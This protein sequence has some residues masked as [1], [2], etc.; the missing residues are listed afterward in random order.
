MSTENVTNEQVEDTPAGES[1][2]ATSNREAAKYR[3]RLRESEAALAASVDRLTMFQ[4]RDVERVAGQSL[5][6]ADDV[7]L[8]GVETHDLLED[9]DTG[10]VSEAKVKAA[11]DQVLEGRPQLARRF[12]DLGGGQ[13]GSAPETA[14]SWSEVLR[15]R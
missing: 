1:V 7:W 8:S 9:D 2:D 5:S 10:L 13:R 11:V 14:A 3:V 4:R 15:G 6:R 12:P